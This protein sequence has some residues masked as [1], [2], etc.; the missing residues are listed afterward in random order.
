MQFLAFK[1]PSG[2]VFIIDEAEA[3]PPLANGYEWT[4]VV[5]PDQVIMAEAEPEPVRESAPPPPQYRNSSPG[6]LDMLLPILTPRDGQ[7]PQERAQELVDA[8]PD[9][10]R[11]KIGQLARALR[12][13]RQLP[14]FPGV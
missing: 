13:P 6:L 2:R 7:S 4:V 3:L 10:L 12:P 11:G 5:R 14:P 1:D 8:L 9:E